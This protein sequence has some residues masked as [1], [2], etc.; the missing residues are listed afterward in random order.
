MATFRPSFMRANLTSKAGRAGAVAGTAQP[1]LERAPGSL[2]GNDD[3]VSAVEKQ[4]IRSRTVDRSNLRDARLLGGRGCGGI[5]RRHDAEDVG[6]ASFTALA[7][8]G[9]VRRSLVEGD[10]GV[11]AAHAEILTG[12]GVTGAK[13]RSQAEEP[14]QHDQVLHFYLAFPSWC[15]GAADRI[16]RHLSCAAKLVGH[17]GSCQ[18]CY[19]TRA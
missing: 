14:S 7:A 3:A 8:E 2:A 16:P 4:D 10:I 15:Q 12:N 13:R 11:D 5:A 6:G 19:R 1:R 17:K 9:V 18:A